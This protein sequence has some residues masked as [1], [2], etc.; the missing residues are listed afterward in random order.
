MSD[1]SLN[2]K[3][4]PPSVITSILNA[5]NDLKAPEHKR[6]MA[7][8]FRAF[9]IENGVVIDKGIEAIK[10]ADTS[11]KEVARVLDEFVSLKLILSALEEGKQV[12]QEQ[13]VKLTQALTDNRNGAKEIKALVEKYPKPAPEP[14]TEEPVQ[15]S[16]TEPAA[17]SNSIKKPSTGSKPK[18]SKQTSSTETDK[19]ETL[20]SFEDALVS[21][22]DTFHDKIAPALGQPVEKFIQDNLST[23]SSVGGDVASL[24]LAAFLGPGAPFVKMFNDLVGMDKIFRKVGEASLFTTKKLLSGVTGLPSILVKGVSGKGSIFTRMWSWFKQKDKDER[25][26]NRKEMRQQKK[27]FKDRLLAIRKVGS[28]IKAAAG[29]VGGFLK[30]GLSF[31]VSLVGKAFGLIGSLFTAVIGKIPFLDKV[32]KLTGGSTGGFIKMIVPFLL[33]A[34]PAIGGG[35]AMYF[36]Y[37]DLSQSKEGQGFLEGGWNSRGAGYAKSVGG[38]AATGAAIGSIVPG[39]GTVVGGLVGAGVGLLSGLYADNKKTVD[40][41]ASKNKAAFVKLGSVL[42]MGPMGLLMSKF[43]NSAIGLQDSQKK[44]AGDLSDVQGNP[45]TISSGQFPFDPNNSTFKGGANSSLSNI[46][47]QAESNNNYNIY[48]KGHTGG[49][50]SEDFSNLTIGQV[51]QRQSVRGGDRVFAFGRYQITPDAMKAAVNA[52]GLPYTTKLT[53]AVQDAIFSEYLLKKKRPEIYNYIT[54]KSNSLSSAVD[55]AAREWA[56]LQGSSGRGMY[57]GTAGNKATVSTQQ[58]AQAL[59]ASRETYARLVNSGMSPDEAWKHAVLGSGAGD[60]NK[61]QVVKDAPRA[62][63]ATLAAGANVAPPKPKKKSEYLPHKTK[64]PETRVITNDSPSTTG[65]GAGGKAANNRVAAI[66][67]SLDNIPFAPDDAMLLNLV[68]CDLL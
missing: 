5:S 9:L 54:G 23:I 50:Y 59:N 49:R 62:M 58:T 25:S 44:M 19:E 11:K 45:A 33:R 8:Q 21:A 42:A 34:L 53:P 1:N 61:A 14:P 52:M 30:T 63:G 64:A 51:I 32:L 56:A 17:T 36:G 39:V 10:H 6:K 37:K 20:N 26:L 41:F 3:D 2:L 46:I 13:I 47:G 43:I 67:G 24:G 22:F 7:Q 15:Q 48:N 28:N 68:V 12:Q 16:T 38:G 4:L 65:L 31:I 27:S 29:S 40:E 60:F 57:D 66:K 18:P 35:A 55:G